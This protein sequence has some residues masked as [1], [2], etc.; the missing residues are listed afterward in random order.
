[1]RGILIVWRDCLRA[2]RHRFDVVRFDSCRSVFQD[3]SSGASVFGVRPH[4]LRR[5]LHSFAALRLVFW[6]PAGRLALHG[7]QVS[8]DGAVFSRE[9]NAAPTSVIAP[10]N[11]ARGTSGSFIEISDD[12]GGEVRSEVSDR[13]HESHG[14]TDDSGREGFRW[15]WPRRRP[16]DRRLRRRLEQ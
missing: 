1:M 11:P 10:R 14:G 8:A 16:S 6:R 5:G 9:A 3:G 15:G 7:D 2:G 4:G 13:V 12:E